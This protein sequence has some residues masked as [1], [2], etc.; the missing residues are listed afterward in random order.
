MAFSQGHLHL[1]S[2]NWCAK[3]HP[4]W[5][6]ET[7]HFL[8][9]KKSHEADVDGAQQGSACCL[10]SWE[11]TRQSVM[12]MFNCVDI[13]K[14]WFYLY[15]VNTKY[16]LMPGKK[17][18]HC[19]CGHKSH[20]PKAMCLTA[21]VCPCPN[22]VTGDSW[23]GKIRTWFFIEQVP[24]VRSLCKWPAGTLDTRAVNVKKVTSKEMYIHTLLL[25]I[26]EKWPAWEEWAIKIQLNNAPVHPRQG[27]LG[28]WL[29]QHLA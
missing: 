19:V 13:D 26:M 25:V 8:D 3:A 27:R 17:P 20:I 23:D 10:L 24:A 18:P 14:N 12:S 2:E 21:V 29:N 11:C 15:Q 9:N 4:S 7:W 28:K 1:S 6:D 16:I 22:P 5:C